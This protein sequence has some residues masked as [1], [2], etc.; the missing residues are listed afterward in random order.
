MD[1]LDVIFTRRSVRKFGSE[2]VSAEDI[3]MILKAAMNAPS[4]HNEQPWQFLVITERAVLDQIAKVH[5]YAQMC[6]QAPLA[7]IPCIDLSAKYDV[8]WSQ[9][10]SAAV[11]NILLTVKALNLGAV[12]LGVYPHEK[13]VKDIK[14]MFALPGEV[15]PFNIIPIGH[16]DVS[17][18]RVDRY[19]VNKVHYNKW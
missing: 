5:P 1:P 13:I 18:G 17:Q 6:L 19:S 7:I 9:D 11:Q 3:D 2:K 4:A 15:I 8:F 16:T 10:M 12:W 14:R